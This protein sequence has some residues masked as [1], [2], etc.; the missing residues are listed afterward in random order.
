MNEAIEIDRHFGVEK[1]CEMISK[2]RIDGK[3][4]RACSDFLDENEGAD[5]TPL[6]FARYL[7]NAGA[8]DLA[9]V[10]MSEMIAIDPG[11]VSR[12]FQ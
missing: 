12:I 6:D 3:F 4:D 5:F 8:P 9:K 10:F 11:K 7:K 1:V 2:C